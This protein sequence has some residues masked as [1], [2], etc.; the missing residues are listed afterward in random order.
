MIKKLKSLPK[1][2]TIPCGCL[3]FLFLVLVIL[4]L[5]FLNAFK[6]PASEIKEASQ[7]L[8]T[9]LDSLDMKAQKVTSSGRYATEGGGL[10]FYAHFSEETINAHRVLKESPKR[11]GN[12][13]EV[14]VLT[15]GGISYRAVG[16][17]LFNEGLFYLLEDKSE[18]YF[19]ELGK[20]QT[21]SRSVLDWDS[22]ERLKKGISFYEKALDLV[23][24]QDNSKLERVDT[25]TVK[26]GKEE[27]MKQ[28]IQD[29]D[30]AGL[31]IYV[32]EENSS[33]SP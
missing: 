7:A 25:A 9:I 3:S 31:L 33:S 16:D 1:I 4:F 15:S 13:L 24:I 30:A 2:V 10:T 23:E 19:K 20:N 11:Q 12:Q 21:S 18:E 22:Q 8:E 26:A 5:L 29:M 14:F 32:P 17:S 6:A 28:L 27:Q